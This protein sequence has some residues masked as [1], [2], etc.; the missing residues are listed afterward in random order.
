MVAR[1]R[2][3]YLDDTSYLTPDF[4]AQVKAELER[5]GFVTDEHKFAPYR[6]TMVEH[7]DLIAARLEQAGFRGSIG[8]GFLNGHPQAGYAYYLYDEGRFASQDEL[9]RAVKAWLDARYGV[10]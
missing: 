1:A 9:D 5:T 2:R 8:T 3:S 4:I 7:R 6:E 10:R